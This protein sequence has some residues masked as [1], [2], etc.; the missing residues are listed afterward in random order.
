M[1]AATGI[2]TGA[3]T[4]SFVTGTSPVSFAITGARD[5]C[6]TEDGVIRFDPGKTGATPV[7]KLTDCQAFSMM[8]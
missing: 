5:F 7:T 8:Q 1:F 3:L 4:T 6:S 2:T